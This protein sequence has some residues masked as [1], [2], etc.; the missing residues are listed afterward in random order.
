MSQLLAT[1]KKELSLILL[2]TKLEQVLYNF[3]KLKDRYHLELYQTNQCVLR[4]YCIT[5][6]DPAIT[7]RFLHKSRPLCHG[8]YMALQYIYKNWLQAHVKYIS[9]FFKVIN[10]EPIKCFFKFTALLGSDCVVTGLKNYLFKNHLMSNIYMFRFMYF[11]L[12]LRT[13][14]LAQNVGKNLQ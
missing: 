10:K 8:D 12:K 4:I 2:F 13:A 5:H 9:I 14:H 6:C 11:S 3:Q 1:S 7:R